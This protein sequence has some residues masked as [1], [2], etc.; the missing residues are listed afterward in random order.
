VIWS[1]GDGEAGLLWLVFITIDWPISH[2]IFDRGATGDGVD[3]AI[4]VIVLGALQ[5]GIIGM[6]LYWL[7]RLFSPKSPTNEGKQTPPKVDT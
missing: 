3:F 7:L 2:L 1:S 6:A 5:W 4:N